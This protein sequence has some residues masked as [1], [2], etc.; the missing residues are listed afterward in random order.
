MIQPGECR[1]FGAE[2]RHHVLLVQI[3]AEDLDRDFTVERLVDGL[4][5]DTHTA[6]P[7][8]F[9]DSIFAERF[10]YHVGARILG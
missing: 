4:V 6:A 1:R 5:H 10:S 9:D 7:E 2:A 8:G 3:G